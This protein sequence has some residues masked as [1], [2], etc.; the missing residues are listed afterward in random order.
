MTIFEIDEGIFV[1]LDNVFKIHVERLS[2]SETCI[3]KFYHTDNSYAI[4]KE[5]DN[6][7]RATDWFNLRVIRSAGSNEILTLKA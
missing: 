6:L 4:S 5:F 1:N 2:G 7:D 3:L